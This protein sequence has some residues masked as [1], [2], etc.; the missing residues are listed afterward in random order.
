VRLGSSPSQ[1][2]NG[3]EIVCDALR[4]STSSHRIDT[5]NHRDEGSAGADIRT[6]RDLAARERLLGESFSR[7]LFPQTF[8][9]SMLLVTGK[10]CVISRDR[11]EQ[12]FGVAIVQVCASQKVGAD[13]F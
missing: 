9:E 8:E 3:C 6:T 10:E 7:R 5:S 11:V 13:H 2:R 4:G 12:D 1:I